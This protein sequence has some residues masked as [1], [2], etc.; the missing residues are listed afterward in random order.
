MTSLRRLGPGVA[1]C[2]AGMALALVGNALLPTVSALL[3]AIV[4]GA[5]V[6]NVVRLPDALQPGI[7]FTGKRILRFGIV[8]LGL[9]VSLTDIASLGWRMVVVVVAIVGLGV[10]AGL[11]IGRWLKLSS[12]LSLLIGSGFSICGAAAVAAVDGVLDAEEENVATAIALV[13][14]FGTLMIPIV[15]GIAA[16]AGLAPHDAALFAGGSIHEVAQVVAAA[17]VIGGGALATAVIVK[18]ARVLMLAP[19]IAVISVRLRRGTAGQGGKRPPIVPLFV[20]GFLAMV[21]VATFRIIPAPALS[22][23]KVVQTAA[24]AAAMFALGLGVKVKSLIKVGPKPF[25]LG[26]GNTL[27]VGVIAYAGMLLAR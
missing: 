5:V 9:Q 16:L 14:L 27:V 3:F 19:V 6:A 25:L 17:G 22:V 15:P 2:L 1:V 10:A 11:L 18:L 23:I 24:L 20:A 26:L 8:L 12:E 21:L 4:L 13:V 7:G